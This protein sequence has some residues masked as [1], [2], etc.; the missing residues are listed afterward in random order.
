MTPASDLLLEAVEEAARL[1]GEV[2]LRHFRAGVAVEWKPDG[3]E[4]T[5]AD[6][7]AERAV[8]EWLDARFPDDSIVGEEFG[9]EQRS[10]PRTWY[11]DP[12]DG[13]KSFV[14]G[15][16]LWGSM[17]AV[18]LNGRVHAGAVCC[19]AVGET[20]VAAT[21]AGCWH[22][23][24]R[25][26][27]SVIDRVDRAA[28]LVTDAQFRT[29][30]ERAPRWQSLSRECALSRTW[31][32][33]YGYVLIATGRAEVMA[34]DRL[35]PWDVA[36]LL[37]ILRESG[38][39]LTDWAGHSGVLGADGLATNQVLAAE[40]RSRLGVPNEMTVPPDR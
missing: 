21:G 33:C 14:R 29:H 20:V 25:A 2:A 24:A 38:G 22:N 26:V 36:A 40:V 31:G 13:T 18:T 11:I 3:S 19:P 7:D 28:I 16:P 15:V 30:P 10:A 6:R 12:I 32:D 5:S 17:V 39:V 4:V 35:N 27:V 9:L 8:R 37:P 34:D 23:G 1:A